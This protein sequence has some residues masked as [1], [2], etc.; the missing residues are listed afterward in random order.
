GRY[1]AAAA[2]VAGICDLSQA[3]TIREISREAANIETIV[4]MPDSQSLLLGIRYEGVR[5]L[6]I[7]GR[8]LRW[9]PSPARHRSIE[10]MPNHR[11]WL[12]EYAVEAHGVR[13]IRAWD[14]TL[15]E[16][17]RE[18]GIP[19]FTALRQLFRVSPSESFICTTA[20]QHCT[21]LIDAETGETLALDQPFRAPIVDIAISPNSQRVGVCYGNGAVRETPLY[22]D[23]DSV[24]FNSILQETFDSH[25]GET[26]CLRYANASTLVT[27]GSD[28]YVR[29][30]QWGDR[31]LL[32]EESHFAPVIAFSPDG[33]E[34]A[35]GWPDSSTL[36]IRDS[37]T[38]NIRV[39]KMIEP[40]AAMTWSPD[41]Q[42]IA[43]VPPSHDYVKVCNAALDER[44]HIDLRQ[45][46]LKCA[47]SR[48]GSLLF[49]MSRD[50]V[51]VCRADNGAVVH[52]VAAGR[53][54]DDYGVANAILLIAI[55][56]GTGKLSFWSPN[57]GVAPPAVMLPKTGLSCVAFSPDDKLLACGASDGTVL[58][59]SVDE[60]RI[61]HELAAHDTPGPSLVFAQDGKALLASA[62]CKTGVWNL[63]DGQLIT[64]LP[65]E[66]V[67]ADRGL[68]KCVW[69]VLRPEDRRPYS[70]VEPLSLH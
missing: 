66:M 54:A 13:E 1:L 43:M 70:F 22:V 12:I 6:A 53:E 24:R 51:R 58:I 46:V 18:F 61:V 48:D 25:S 27:A 32:L 17:V 4:F 39:E 29:I 59:W 40:P 52:Q 26:R 56:D 31:R 14:E 64:T 57:A 34:L 16:V 42:C 62:A 33:A 28:G 19:R 36:R 55:V 63:T 45:R 41:F 7:D 67:A 38:G 44:F 37:H 47:F 49:V 20:Q 15:G 3:F 11:Q 68:T 35:Y 60:R 23:Q 21:D 30:W 8:E 65:R 10:F 2:D 69:T 9:I 50:E 5:H